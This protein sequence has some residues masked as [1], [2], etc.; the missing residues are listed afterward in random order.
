MAPRKNDADVQPILLSHLHNVIQ[1]LFPAALRVLRIQVVSFIDKQHAAN[2][3]FNKLLGFCSAHLLQLVAAGLV[4][5]AVALAH[6]EL[7]Q[8]FAEQPRNGCFAGARVAEKQKIESFGGALAGFHALKT[9]Q[10][11]VDVQRHV[12]QSL[13]AGEMHDRVDAV[14]RRAEPAITLLKREQTAK[15]CVLQQ[16]TEF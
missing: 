12:L 13:E 3:V 11:L 14:A 1:N 10:T 16:R 4:E 6:A 5:S 15:V 9:K 8:Q 2:R 7:N